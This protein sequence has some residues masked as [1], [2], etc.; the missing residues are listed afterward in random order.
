MRSGHVRPLPAVVRLRYRGVDGQRAVFASL[1]SRAR[2]T[3]CNRIEKSRSAYRGGGRALRAGTLGDPGHR[4]FPMLRGPTGHTRGCQYRELGGGGRGG[5][6]REVQN[7]QAQEKGHR[8]TAPRIPD[9][10]KLCRLLEDVRGQGKQQGTEGTDGGR[11]F[12]Q[13]AAVR[14]NSPPPITLSRRAHPTPLPGPRH[15][16][17]TTKKRRAST[18]EPPPRPG[19]HERRT[20]TGARRPQGRPRTRRNPSN[21]QHQSSTP[22][23][24]GKQPYIMT[25]RQPPAGEL[26]HH[27]ILRGSI[28][29]RGNTGGKQGRRERAAVGASVSEEAPRI[30]SRSGHRSG[31]R[32]PPRASGGRPARPASRRSP[33]CPSRTSA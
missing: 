19:C 8:C 3:A 25:K 16:P 33:C 27:G 2:R 4:T 5:G 6:C 29:D 14:N 9:F 21:E 30:P 32:P 26:I 17:E 18:M 23:G 28:A 11:A 24:R 22:F 10:L 12:R 31:C 7:A 1:R 15:Q 13:R 20:T